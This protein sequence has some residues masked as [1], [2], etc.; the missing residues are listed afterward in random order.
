MQKSMLEINVTT[1]DKL[2]VIEGPNYKDGPDD[3]MKMDSITVSPDQV[4]ILIQWLKEAKEELQ[5][6][7]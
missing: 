5:Q 4:D 6:K 1:A 3:M 2:I 7:Q